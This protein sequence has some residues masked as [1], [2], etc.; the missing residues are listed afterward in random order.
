MRNARLFQVAI[1][2]SLIL[3]A[4]GAVPPTTDPSKPISADK[5]CIGAPAPVQWK[6]IVVLMFENKRYD[7]VIGPAPYITALAHKCAT[8]LNGNDSNS[9]VDGS[10]DGSYKSKPSYA[11]LTNGLSP[12]A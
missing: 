12:S 2:L 8:A 11:T 9:K 6:H 7:Q 5:P 4:C 1:V 3:S 10:A